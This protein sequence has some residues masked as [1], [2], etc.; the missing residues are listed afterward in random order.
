MAQDHRTTLSD[1]A[2]AAQVSVATVSK[3]VNGKTDI[4]SD[5]REKVEQAIEQL[6]YFHSKQSNHPSEFIDMA[7]HHLDSSWT[8]D[9]LRGATEALKPSHARI[10]VSQ[11]N[12]TE[13][14]CGEWLEEVAA[15]RPLGVIVVFSKPTITLAKRLASRQIPC[16]Y[17][18]PWGTPASGPGIMSVQTDNWSGGVFATRHLIELGHRAIATIT[19]PTSV[20][21]ANARLDGYRNALT[22]AGIPVQ[23]KYIRR[24][25]FTQDSG[26]T[27]AMDLLEQDDRPTAIFAQSDF[28]AF[29]VYRAAHVLNL[30]IPQDLSVIGYD[31][32]PTSQLLTP[33]LTTIA[34]PTSQ[35]AAAAVHMIQDYR[36]GKSV[37]ERLIMPTSLVLRESTAAP[38]TL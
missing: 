30:R 24:G 20:M 1:V 12:S 6:G 14:L 28:L 21:C 26:Y 3:V 27:L 2:N 34:Q 16:V 15:R 11:A 37:D 22:E 25:E 35:M 31:D 10:V 5:T 17:L 29:G 36:A 19:G 9:L 4:S 32:I 33:P 38:A 23:E 7:F 18:D 8:I 13:E